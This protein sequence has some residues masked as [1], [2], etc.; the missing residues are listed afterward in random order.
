MRLQCLFADFWLHSSVA[1]AAAVEVLEELVEGKMGAGTSGEG[2]DEEVVIAA[3]RAG[4]DA[5]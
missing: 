3:A 2:S 1:A 4:K 5:R